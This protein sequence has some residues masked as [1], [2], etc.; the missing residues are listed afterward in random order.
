MDVGQDWIE[1]I[2]HM[3]NNLLT[4][5]FEN[6]WEK[7]NLVQ[8]LR[9][10]NV[11]LILKKNKPAEECPPAIPTNILTVDSKVVSV[12]PAHGLDY[13]TVWI[14]GKILIQE[15]SIINTL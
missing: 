15:K 3:V 6:S 8:T 7:S 9:Q 5:L 10:A 12:I 2:L 11:T 14:K 13:L 1:I 4:K